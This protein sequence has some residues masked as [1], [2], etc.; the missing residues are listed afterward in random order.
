MEQDIA[1]IEDLVSG[2]PSQDIAAYIDGELTPDA[3]L[4]LE[5][6]LAACRTCSDEL[7]LQKHFLNALT[8]SLSGE[9][10]VSEDFTKRIVTSAESS[11]SGLRRRSE[12]LAALSVCCGLLLFVL[13]TLGA[14]ARGTFFSF[15]DV[16]GQLAAV[17][18]FV[19]HS[20]YDLAVGVVVILRT[21][22]AQPAFG[23]ATAVVVTA[24]ALAALY[25]FSPIRFSRKK[26]DQLESGN[27]F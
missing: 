20:C 21:I 26:I 7:N 24:F 8:G 19:S 2:C 6:H 3:E 4:Q 17:V 27:G 23:V 5:F 25:K 14:S 11:V 13:F 15:F 9:F 16:I 12:W 1:P 22:G 10:E 18:S